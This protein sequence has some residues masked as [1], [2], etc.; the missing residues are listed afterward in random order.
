M[1]TAWSTSTTA[2][3]PSMSCRVRATNAAITPRKWTFAPRYG[4]ERVTGYCLTAQDSIKF[5]IANKQPA[6]GMKSGFASFRLSA[7]SMVVVY[8]DHVGQ[9]LFTTPAMLPR[10]P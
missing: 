10:R 1:T 9:T 7:A 2:R 3:S 6:D 4:S 8:H 5:I